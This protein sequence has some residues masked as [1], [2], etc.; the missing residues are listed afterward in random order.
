[1][2][3]RGPKPVPTAILKARGSWRADRPGEPEALGLPSCPAWLASSDPF[4]AEVWDDVL[5]LL[6]A[7]RTVAEID[8]LALAIL[9]QQFSIWRRCSELAEV[10]DCESMA[11]HRLRSQANAALAQVLRLSQ[12]F[13]LTPA[14]RAGMKV[15][16]ESPKADGKTRFFASVN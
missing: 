2:G 14:D 7:Q 6:V 3:K 15:E 12:R 8:W 11:C 10:A 4:A 16:G 5:P 9:C 1:M 13:G